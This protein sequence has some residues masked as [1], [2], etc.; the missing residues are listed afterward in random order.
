MNGYSKYEQVIIA[1]PFNPNPVAVAERYRLVYGGVEG[2]PLALETTYRIETIT[3]G[4]NSYEI[5]VTTMKDERLRPIY[6]A[7]R[8]GE[9]YQAAM[10]VRPIQNRR[11]IHIL[12]AMPIEDLPP[13]EILY[14]SYY[15][16]VYKTVNDI[17]RSKEHCTRADIEQFY[18][19]RTVAKY[20]PHLKEDFGVKPVL[21]GNN[22]FIEALN[23]TK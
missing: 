5:T 12:C 10:R 7:W 18:N 23:Y 2:E 17:I 13:T 1:Q 4:E 6:E 20:W 22:R 19:R 16:E 14:N 21:N 8:Q 11:H 15:D 3:D 9:M